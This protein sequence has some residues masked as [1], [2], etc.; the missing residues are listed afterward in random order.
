[1]SCVR[2]RRQT[3]LAGRNL[4]RRASP[5]LADVEAIT[6]ASNPPAQHDQ[7]GLDRTQFDVVE[8][9][10]HR[11]QALLD[12]IGARVRQH[13]QGRAPIRITM[14]FMRRRDAPRS[15]NRRQVSPDKISMLLRAHNASH[16][17]TQMTSR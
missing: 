7:S 16:H 5:R 15:I 2:A 1:M 14:A 10:C 13:S 6:V 4:D 17:D 12:L 9:L 3:D 11:S 8:R